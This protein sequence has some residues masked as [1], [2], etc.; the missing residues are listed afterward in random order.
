MKIGNG[1][2]SGIK[3]FRDLGIE[4]ILSLFIYGLNPLIP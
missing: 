3:R 2:D 1:F 4:G